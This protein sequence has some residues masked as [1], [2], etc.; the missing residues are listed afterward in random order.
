METENKTP[1]TTS[2]APSVSSLRWSLRFLFKVVLP[3]VCV[4][5]AV[6]TA[7]ILVKTGP[8]AERKKPPQQARLVTV[9]SVH[10]GDVPTTV[11]ALGTVLGAREITINPEVSGRITSISPELI[12]GGLIQKGEELVQID[13]RD[14]EAIV[15]QRESELA[16]AQL[17]LKL[18]QG[19]QVVAA[20][21]Y[22]M[23]SEIVDETEKELV[24]R[25]PHLAGAKASLASAEAAFEK[26]KLDVQRCTIVAPFNAIIQEKLVDVGARVSPTSPILSIVGTDEFWIEV[27]VSEDQLK[28]ITIPDRNETDG[29]KVT[30]Y[31][32][33]VWGAGVSRQGAVIRLL[34]QLE[35]AGRR[36]QL[37]I[38][39]NDPLCLEDGA[40][41]V[42]K[43]LIDSYVSVEIEGHLLNS[44]IAVK[45]DYLHDGDF[46]W[47]MNDQNRL[48]I[49]PV[50]IVFRDL[51]FVYVT[52]GLEDG[53]R[54][55]TS[56]LAAPVDGML[57][58]LESDP[59]VPKAKADTAKGAQ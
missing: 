11:D 59:V 23:L 56:E 48:N 2:D 29:S 52:D 49:Q 42:P 32:P 16:S 9:E 14:Y 27:M 55:V 1:N 17:A 53:Q 37:L 21:E 50:E 30:V 26:A 3:I 25:K 10:R 12:P 31:N 5:G 13:S 40:G 45:R 6:L 36:A 44:V 15:K 20:Q 28:W 34:G 33:S 58:R 46:V 43:L 47:V 24:L 38:S 41:D 19:N 4:V 7:V 57:L 22:D 35:T 18:E 54:I 51:D 8:K 39:V